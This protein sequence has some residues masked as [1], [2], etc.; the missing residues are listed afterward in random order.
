VRLP[1]IGSQHVGRTGDPPQA[2][3][4]R[5][6]NNDLRAP[7][8]RTCLHDLEQVVTFGGQALQLARESS[9]GYVALRLR[10]LRAEFGPLVRDGRIAELGTEIDA[11]S[12]VRGEG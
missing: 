11:L 2:R 9:S 7:E 1:T 6:E 3:R 4:P 12:T 8:V 10:D 5:P